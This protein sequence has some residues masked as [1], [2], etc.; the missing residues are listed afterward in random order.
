MQQQ[1]VPMTRRLRLGSGLDVLNA[2]TETASDTDA[3]AVADVL[4]T[5]VERAVYRFYPVIED[6]A[7]ARELIVVLRDDLAVRVRLDDVEKF[8][9]V[10]IGSTVGALEVG[11]VT[12]AEAS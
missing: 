12:A 10:F 11:K 7:V 5:I 2:W 1:E 3:Q 4:F 6:S 9:I 8:G